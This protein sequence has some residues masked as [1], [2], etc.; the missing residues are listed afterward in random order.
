MAAH[1]PARL[2]SDAVVFYLFPDKPGPILIGGS[3]LALYRIR[4]H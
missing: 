3:A 4:G 1:G 2:R